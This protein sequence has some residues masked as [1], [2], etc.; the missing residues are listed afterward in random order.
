MAIAKEIW[1]EMIKE[2]LYPDNSFL[3]ESVDM[4]EHVEHN[5]INLAEA[6]VDPEVLI[7]NAVF[8]V[9]I[10]ERTDQAIDLALH[11]FDTKNT[12]VRNLEEKE[13][14]YN[15][16][17]SVIRSHRNALRLKTSTFA[18]HSWAPTKNGVFT[19]VLKTTGAVKDGIKSLTFE[20]VLLLESKFRDLDADMSNLVL[21]LN[22]R[23]LADLRSEDIKLYKEILMENKLFSFKLFAFSKQ[24]LF[25]TTTGQK[26]AFGAVAGAN[27]TM[28]SLAYSID[29]VMRAEG[30]YEVFARYKDP[31]ARGDIIGF[32]QRFTALPIRNKL[33]GSIYSD[34]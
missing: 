24:A 3:T 29:E 12:V 7:D 11:S 8:P 21:I 16:M 30:D 33:I 9:P 2:G 14:S 17:D 23:H 13:T 18:A 27:D 32:Q 19:P 25:D 22:T 4:S 10:E 20:D 1:I 34:K 6:G 28:G 15:K 26:K 5:K 31:E